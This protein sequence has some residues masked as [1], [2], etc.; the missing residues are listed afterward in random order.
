MINF[1]TSQHFLLIQ[2]RFKYLAVYVSEKIMYVTQLRELKFHR[3]LIFKLHTK[4]KPQA[5]IQM[6]THVKLIN[7]MQRLKNS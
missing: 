4:W 5:P 2:N 7:L 6:H 3:Q 1:S